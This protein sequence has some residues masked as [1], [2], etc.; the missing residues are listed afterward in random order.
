V[1]LVAEIVEKVPSLTKV[2]QLSVRYRVREN[3]AGLLMKIK[4]ALE[5]SLD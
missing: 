3:A 5:G 4:E 1:L 2:G